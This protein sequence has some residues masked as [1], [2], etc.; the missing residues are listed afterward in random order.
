MNI[1]LNYL[2]RDGSNYKNY[3]NA[4]FSNPDN[5]SSEI[6]EKSICSRLIDGEYFIAA[7]WELPELFFEQ[8]NQDDHGWHEFQSI[9]LTQSNPT[10][11]KTIGDLLKLINHKFKLNTPKI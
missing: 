6:I 5:I 10:S 7:D 4:I 2:Y 1:Q 8:P 9:E 11:A 3:G